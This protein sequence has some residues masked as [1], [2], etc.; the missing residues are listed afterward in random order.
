MAG[1]TQPQPPALILECGD[2]EQGQANSPSMATRSPSPARMGRDVRGRTRTHLHLAAL[3]QVEGQVLV[4]V[5]RE[6][7]GVLGVELQHLAQSP[8]PDVLQVAV[9]QRL[10]VRVGLDHLVR[11]AQVGSDQIPFACRRGPG[12]ADGVSPGALTQQKGLGGSP[13]NLPSPRMAKTTL[14][15]STSREPEQTK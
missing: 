5:G 7:A 11:A 12:C 2:R 13:C 8:Q 9:G 15:F 3:P 10:H 4:D 1:V 14:S 6:L